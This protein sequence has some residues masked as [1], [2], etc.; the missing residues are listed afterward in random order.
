MKNLADEELALIIES[1]LATWGEGEPHL[2]SV[3][4]TM[5]HDGQVIGTQPSSELVGD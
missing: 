3:P 1:E 5:S 4:C 2:F